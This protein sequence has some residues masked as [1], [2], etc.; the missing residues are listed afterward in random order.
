MNERVPN[1]VINNARL[2]FCNFSGAPEKYSRNPGRHFG[3]VIDD[4]EQAAALAE[5]GWNVK[6]FIPKHQEEGENIVI[7]FI[8]VKISFDVV[9]PTIKL[10][11]NNKPVAIG[12]EELD[13]LDNVRINS[14]KVAI[15]P[16]CW[17]VD[18]KSG[19]K[20]YLKTLYLEI[21]RDEFAYLYDD[22]PF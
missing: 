13:T 11:T 14:A 8:D 12:E 5:E 10:V 18:G 2:I 9:P 19:I 15:R 17:E 20:G 7:H 1:I 3:V 6:T 4:P 22:E 21:E 16:Y